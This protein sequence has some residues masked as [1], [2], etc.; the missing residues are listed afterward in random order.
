MGKRERRGKWAGLTARKIA[1]LTPYSTSTIKTL[2]YGLRKKS[3]D[4]MPKDVG[5]IIAYCWEKKSNEEIN[6]FIR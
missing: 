6:K 4:V 1:S 3:E 2:L 5:L